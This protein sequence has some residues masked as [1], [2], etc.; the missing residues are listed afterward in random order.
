[1]LDAIT[2]ASYVRYT[3]VHNLFT[4]VGFYYINNANKNVEI[5]ILHILLE[6]HINSQHNIEKTARINLPQYAALCYL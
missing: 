6:F 2:V 5:N 3:A 1:M 4:H